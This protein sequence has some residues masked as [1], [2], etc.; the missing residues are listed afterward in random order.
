M[1]FSEPRHGEEAQPTTPSRGGS[2]GILAL[3]RH[4]RRCRAR[5]DDY[6]DRGHSISQV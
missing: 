5:D 4:A 2:N 1:C 6:E 3:D